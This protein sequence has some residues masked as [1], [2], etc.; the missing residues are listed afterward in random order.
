MF[1]GHH[2]RIMHAPLARDVGMLRLPVPIVQDEVLNTTP[3]RIGCGLPKHMSAPYILHES[4]A[5]R[6]DG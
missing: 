6:S 1:K 2:A 4:I 3:L 5:K